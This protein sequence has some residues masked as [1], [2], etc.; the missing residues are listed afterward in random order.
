MENAE[1]QVLLNKNLEIVKT[2][3]KKATMFGKSMLILSIFDVVFGVLAIFTTSLQ[4]IAFFASATSL[5]A[6]TIC[7][8]I[9]QISKIRQLDKSLKTA[10][11][12]SVAWFVNK[13][14]KKENK[15]VK[16][17]K[18]S[19]IQIA[20]IIGAV[21]GIAFAITSV[22]VPQ[23]V[24][25]GNVIYN[26]LIATGLETLCAVAGT[27]KGYKKLT[28]EEIAKIKYAQEQKEKLAKEAEVEKAKAE[29]AHIEELKKIVAEAEETKVE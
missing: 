26:I 23:I 25:F 12:L 11:W 29:L 18:L 17:E 4:L 5:T 10:K 20:S 28:E 16:T 22:F 3:E 6:I 9:I 24:F 1:L 2:L 13:Y 8:R 19:K 27:F 7:G 14:S 15:E 21:V